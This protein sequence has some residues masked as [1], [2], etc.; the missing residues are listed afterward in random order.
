MNT[1]A[2]VLE[3]INVLY[4]KVITSDQQAINKISKHFDTFDPD[5]P[6]R[7]KYKMGLWN[8]MISHFNKR[9]MTLPFGLWEE[10]LN[11]CNA[12]GIQV[13]FS[14]FTY[15]DICNKKVDK[16]N[17]KLFAV[18][19]LNKTIF[20]MRD[21]Q[22]DAFHRSVQFTNGIILAA[23]GSGKSLMVYN[24]IRFNMFFKRT[25]KI[26]LIVPNVS[27]VEQMYTDFKEYGWT[28]I[29][30]HVYRLHN[31]VSEADK[32]KINPDMDKHVLITTWQSIVNKRE[33]F[34]SQFDA[35]IIDECLDG[36]TLIRMTDGCEKKIRDIVIGDNILSY[37]VDDG[38]VVN[39]TVMNV[40]KNLN[41]SS[42][43]KMYELEFDS[44]I[45]IEVTGN[46]KFLTK[47][48]GYVRADE[49]TDIDDIVEI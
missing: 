23:T 29:D 37:N 27:L 16:N 10:L 25:N 8:G 49:L 28:D 47:N 35:V 45:K 14:N 19:T 9:T 48:R 1:S 18:M 13:T 30:D 26:I 36:D 20:T 46:H 3:R 42:T 41:I 6:Y 11:F 40:H 17:L 22:L 33:S 21:Y 4:L 2:I 7:P 38:V 32:K 5:A 31:T 34:F 44:G 43:E 12:V 39:D 24:N 15:D